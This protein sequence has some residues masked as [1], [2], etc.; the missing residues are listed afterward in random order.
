[1]CRIFTNLIFRLFGNLP[2]IK[3]DT[4]A[5]SNAHAHARTGEKT[6]NMLPPMESHA[7][8]SHIQNRLPPMVSRYNNLTR[9]LIN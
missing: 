7:C 6:H 9:K 3:A 2:V 8:G 1:M 4:S 5:Q